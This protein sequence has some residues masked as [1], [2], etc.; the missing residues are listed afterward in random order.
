MVINANNLSIADIEYYTSEFFAILTCSAGNCKLYLPTKEEI[1]VD[2]STM[3][4]NNKEPNSLDDFYND[5][6]W[7]N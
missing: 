4:D 3:F 5:Y 1:D 7:L 2:L 6:P